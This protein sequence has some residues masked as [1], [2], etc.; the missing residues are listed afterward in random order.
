MNESWIGDLNVSVNKQLANKWP[1]YETYQLQ[2]DLK[3]MT[4][5]W[6]DLILINAHLFLQRNKIIKH[7]VK[8][9]QKKATAAK[10]WTVF[11]K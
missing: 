3:R 11:T 6:K 5:L 10:K 7:E 4:A 9:L 1:D 8:K 2:L